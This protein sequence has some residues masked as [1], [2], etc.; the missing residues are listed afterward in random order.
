M[1]SI[2]TFLYFIRN[3]CLYFLLSLHDM[4]KIEKRRYING[5]QTS[6]IPDIYH[7]PG[8]SSSWSFTIPDIYHPRHLPSRTFTISD[9]YHPG[10]LLT[11]TFTNPDIYQP[12]HLPFQTKLFITVY[13]WTQLC[14]VPREYFFHKLL[15]GRGG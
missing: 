1:H 4:V 11:R 14:G 9:I 3:V 2:S 12:G 13:D 8:H 5:N 10:H 6:T 7:Q 15:S